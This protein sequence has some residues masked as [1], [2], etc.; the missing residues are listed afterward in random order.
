MNLDPGLD[1]L[2]L[3]DAD[4]ELDAAFVPE[5][6]MICRSLRHRGEDLLAQV[7]GLAE[8]AGR[9]HDGN[10]AALFVGVALAA[11]PE[12]PVLPDAGGGREYTPA[13]P[14]PDVTTTSV[15]VD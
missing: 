9:A 8:C 1:T 4:A 11:F 2:R 12:L 7:G 15:V 3:S 13:D 14:R 6:G 10:P 5:A